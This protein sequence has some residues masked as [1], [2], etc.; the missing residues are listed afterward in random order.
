M[1]IQNV[2]V[3]FIRCQV[4]GRSSLFLGNS[5]AGSCIAD[6]RK[7]I[8]THS[9][10][11]V[12]FLVLMTGDQMNFLKTVYRH[13]SVYSAYIKNALVPSKINVY[14]NDDPQAFFVCAFFL[15]TVI[16]TGILDMSIV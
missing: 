9:E 11:H 1:H 16:L 8:Y 5:S 10:T 15:C 13:F 2:S 7:C 12:C 14:T 3:C 4:R 6:V